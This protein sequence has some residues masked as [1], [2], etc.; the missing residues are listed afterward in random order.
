MG[1]KSSQ[2]IISE[3]VVPLMSHVSHTNL[4]FRSC[5]R[6]FKGKCILELRLVFVHSPPRVWLLEDNQKEYELSLKAQF[7][8]DPNKQ[9]FLALKNTKQAGEDVVSMIERSGTVLVNDRLHPLERAGLSVQEDL[10]LLQHSS[11]GWILKA[12]SVCFPS[13]WQLSEKIGKG[14]SHI[15]GPVDGYEKHL[16]KKVDNFFP[17]WLIQ[18][19]LEL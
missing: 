19:V 1:A 15:H 3:C 6:Y 12:A 10:C 5:V 11:K 8:K 18:I 2:Q 14:M 9:V 13:R 16:S 17:I 4:V 7:T